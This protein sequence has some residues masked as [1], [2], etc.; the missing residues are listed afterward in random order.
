MAAGNLFTRAGLSSKELSNRR[1]KLMQTL[2][3]V[4]FI[5][6]I[7]T[8]DL[9]NYYTRSYKFSTTNRK[10]VIILSIPVR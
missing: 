4:V 8:S 1:K 3:Y 7:Q 9:H 6:N 2:P 5:Q 10:I